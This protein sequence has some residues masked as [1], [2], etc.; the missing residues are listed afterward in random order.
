MAIGNETTDFTA[1]LGEICV[2]H[3]RL[4]NIVVTETIF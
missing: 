4:K 1:P 2:L 3:V